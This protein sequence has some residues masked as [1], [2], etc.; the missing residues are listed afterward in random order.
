MR[1]T[2][3]E[4]H[5]RLVDLD[6]FV[7]GPRLTRLDALVGFVLAESSV[8][9]DHERTGLNALVMLASP[10]SG[11][12]RPRVVQKVHAWVLCLWKEEKVISNYPSIQASDPLHS[13][14]RI[15]ADS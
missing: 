4:E 9:G 15:Q 7:V 12:R 10:G 2:F 13:L 6:V 1:A 3:G 5:P 8:L 14:K 11:E